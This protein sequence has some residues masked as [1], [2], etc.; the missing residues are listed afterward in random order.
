MAWTSFSAWAPMI[1]SLLALAV[2]GLALA[3]IRALEFAPEVLAG[4][5]ILPRASRLEGEAKLLHGVPKALAAS[6]ANGM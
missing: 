2:A 5:V 1:L 4:D 3:K 6:V